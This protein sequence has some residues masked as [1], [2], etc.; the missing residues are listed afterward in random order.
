MGFCSVLGR[1][2][3]KKFVNGW[4]GVWGKGLIKEF[5]ICWKFEGFK[6]R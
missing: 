5:Q 1:K 2:V 6:V 4:L 3:V